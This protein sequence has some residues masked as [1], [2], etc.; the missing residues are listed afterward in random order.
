MTEH[1]MDRLVAE[2]VMG[3]EPFYQDDVIVS[4]ITERGELFFSTDETS[5]WNPSADI[6]DAWLVNEKFFR[7]HIETGNGA[8]EH[9]V[10]IR[11][12]VGWMVSYAYAKTVPEAIC[13]AALKAKGVEVK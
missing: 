12:K 2:K 6:Q 7:V 10:T 4:W 3:W 9:C 13:L 1:E 5:E 11:D 8:N